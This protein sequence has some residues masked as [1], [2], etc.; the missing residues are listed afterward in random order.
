VVGG[1]WKGNGARP[2]TSFNGGGY[3]L[4]MRRGSGWGEM[5]VGMALDMV[6]SGHD[7][8]AFYRSGNGGRRVVK[9]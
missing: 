4:S 6:E 2:A 8:G 3:L 1:G 9:E 5:K 7:V